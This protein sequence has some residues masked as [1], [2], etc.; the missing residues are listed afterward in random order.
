MK[1]ALTIAGSDSGGGAGIQ[2]DLKTF[3]AHGVYGCCVVT[4]VTAQN[5]QEVCAACELPTDIVQA[6]LNAVLDDLDA[7]ATKTG[8]L[9][10]AELID[11]IVDIIADRKVSPLIVDPVMVATSGFSLIDDDAVEHLV[12][13][14]LPLATVATPNL[15]EAERL[16]GAPIT[17]LS[18]MRNAARRIA[19][20]GPGAVVVK[21]GHSR[22][23]A[24]TDVLYDGED[25]YVLHTHAGIA[26]YAIHGSGCTFSAAI[27]ARMA[28]GDSIAG[29]VAA[30]KRYISWAIVHAPEVGRGHRPAAHFYFMGPWSPGED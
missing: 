21:G 8:M 13:R 3:A 7:G 12:E 22:F 4:A 16:I 19:T 23:S 26:P 17:S 14:L 10:S 24:G 9:S 30:A 27:T 18:E 6:Q 25:T 2:A 11:A 5:T 28:M 20:M 29:A 1:V 15:P